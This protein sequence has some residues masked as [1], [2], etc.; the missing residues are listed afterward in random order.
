MEKTT[1][2]LTD[3]DADSLRALAADLGLLNPRMRGVGSIS[4]LMQ[5]LARLYQ[6]DT[7]AAKRVVVTLRE[8]NQ[9]T[10]Q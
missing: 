5:M 8:Q 2:A 1:V 4:A 6:S 3:N 7:D 9:N 10:A